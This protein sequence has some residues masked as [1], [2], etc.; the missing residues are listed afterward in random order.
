MALSEKKL[1]P[2]RTILTWPIGAVGMV[3][4][5]LLTMAAGRFDP[6]RDLAHRCACLW[7]KLILWVSGVQVALDG[8][9][10]LDPDH[11]QV[12]VA[13]H[14]GSFDIWALAAVLPVQFRW[15][16]KKE[17]FSIPT[18]GAAMR[19]AGYVAVDRF[20]P[21]QAVKD[22]RECRKRL[23]QG[24]SLLIF[25]EGTRSSD[26]KVGQFKPGAFLLAT[27]AKLPI[28]PI[29]IR[30]SFQIMPKNSI[31]LS[32]RTIHISIHPPIPTRGLNRE[33]QKGLAEKVRRI[34]AREVEKDVRPQQP[35]CC[36]NAAC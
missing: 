4:I 13:N 19:A 12:L 5:A 9:Q 15:V 1:A 3:L 18:L 33:E 36:C 27:Q 23:K 2:L 17:L 35:D 24:R 6:S 28:V 30:G 16:V 14:Q 22:M 31:W 25:P 32:P 10:H 34:I 21:R 7:G 8:V 29:G 26:G 20:D 11:P